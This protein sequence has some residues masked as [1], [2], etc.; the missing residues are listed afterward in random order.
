MQRNGIA[1]KALVVCLLIAVWLSGCFNGGGN[2]DNGNGNGGGNGSAETNHPPTASAPPLV[3]VED[4]DGSTQIAV[5]D[6]DSGQQHRFVIIN[7]P[8]DGTASVDASGRVTYTPNVGFIGDDQLDVEVIDNGALPLSTVVV[9]DI[10][11]SERVPA[12]GVFVG[13]WLGTWTSV[14]PP[15]FG[16]GEGSI[17]VDIEQETLPFIGSTG[18]D[19]LGTLTM[20]GPDKETIV[21]IPVF[22]SGRLFNVLGN[23]GTFSIRPSP[24]GALP[25]EAPSLCQMIIAGDVFA[26][27]AGVVAVQVVGPLL[28]TGGCTTVPRES[29]TFTLDRQF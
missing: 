2:G 9:I 28:I 10:T 25:G 19:L 29:A 22:G 17:M 13:T 7:P 15:E 16:G 11:V 14:I 20:T 1:C 24:E 26:D 8:T 18:F 4:S 27:E 5:S 21:N 3:T 12:T 6:P 23:S